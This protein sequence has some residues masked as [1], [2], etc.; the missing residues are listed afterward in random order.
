MAKY[1]KKLGQVSIFLLAFLAFASIASAHVTVSPGEV[2]QG[3][4]EIFTVR[5]PT[6]GEQPT[7]K[8]EVKI[9]SGVEVSRVE[10]KA[11]WSYE[12][13]KNGDEKVTA[14]TW[15]TDGEGLLPSEFT[16]FNMQGKVGEDTTSLEWKAYQTY[17]G[18][19]IVEWVGAEGSDKPASVTEVTE[20]TGGGHDSTTSENASETTDSTETQTNI[21]LY[22][23][24]AALLIGGAALILALRKK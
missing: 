13:E 11:G 3:A 7:T 5:V 8:I 14:I 6:E 15:T 16:D 18:G 9:P 24:V 10:P 22:L 17:N 2:E 1:K 4:Y 23:S 20:S 12:M 19:K 21:P